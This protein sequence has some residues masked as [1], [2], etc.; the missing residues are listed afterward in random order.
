MNAQDV[1][2]LLLR[3][4]AALETPDD[5]TKEEKGHVIE[6]CLIAADQIGPLNETEITDDEDEGEVEFDEDNED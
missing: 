6:D 4:A 5:L 1:R 2:R 3:A